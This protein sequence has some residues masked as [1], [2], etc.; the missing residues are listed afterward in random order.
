MSAAQFLAPGVRTVPTISAD[1]D[2]DAA[3]PIA[4]TPSDFVERE[5]VTWATLRAET[6]R[7]TDLRQFSVIERGERRSLAIVRAVTVDVRILDLDEP[8]SEAEV[9]LGCVDGTREHGVGVVSRPVTQTT[10]SSSAALAVEP[11]GS[12]RDGDG[13]LLEAP[14]S[15]V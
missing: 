13:A 14:V 15:V 11:R 4:F 6:I 9:I 7:I 3:P 8:T 1:A 5:T 2:V 10:L 12:A